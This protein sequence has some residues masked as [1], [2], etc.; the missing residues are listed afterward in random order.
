MEDLE[1]L[2]DAEDHEEPVHPQSIDVY[3]SFVNMSHFNHL[4]YATIT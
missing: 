1:E 2:P 3:M 4:T